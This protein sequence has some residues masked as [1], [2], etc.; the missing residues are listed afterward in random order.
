MSLH[1]C[2]AAI[3]TTV[4][5][6]LLPPNVKNL[7]NSVYFERKK[8]IIDPLPQ[9]SGHLFNKTGDYFDHPPAGK[10]RPWQLGNMYSDHTETAKTVGAKPENLLHRPLD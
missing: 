6:H 10:T 9:S 8:L 5:L 4:L 1:Q 7:F 2:Y 3:P